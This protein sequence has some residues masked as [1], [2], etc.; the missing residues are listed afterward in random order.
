MGYDI[1]T[2]QLATNILAVDG[3]KRLQTYRKDLDISINEIS[4]LAW[5]SKYPSNDMNVLTQT[6][7]MDDFKFPLLY[8]SGYLNDRIEIIDASLSIKSADF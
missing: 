2:T 1:N 6:V 8:S 7:Y 4:F 5:N 3:V